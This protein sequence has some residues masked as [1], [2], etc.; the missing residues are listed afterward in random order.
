MGAQR[1]NNKVNGH[2]VLSPHRSVA[3]PLPT[4]VGRFDVRAFDMASGHLYVAVSR[5][6]LAGADGVLC[7]LHSECLTGDVFGSL[8]CDCGTQLRTALRLI[9]AEDRGVLIYATGHEGRGIG[10][11]NKLRAY[12]VQDGGA[13]TVDANVLLGLPIDGRDYGDAAAVLDCL[14][15]SSVRLLTNNPAKVAGLRAHGTAV[16]AIV[17]LPTVGHARNNGYLRTKELRLGH[18]RPTGPPID[19]LPDT[20]PGLTVDVGVLLGEVRPQPDRPYVA[21][22]YAQTIDGRIA[23]VGGRAEQISGAPEQMI[24][25]ALRAACDAV[26]VGRGTV[27]ADDPRLTV[28]AVPGVSPR[29]VVLDSALRVAAD[30]RVLDPDAATTIVTTSNAPTDRREALQRRGVHVVVVDEDADHRPDLA[31][32]LGALRREGVESVLVEGGA[33]VITGL[34]AARL[35]DR[36]IVAIAPLVVGSGVEA[37]GELGIRRIGDGIRLV[38]RSVHPVGDDILLAGDVA[39]AA[40]SS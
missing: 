17:P 29:R 9:E 35:V 2:R 23:T 39:C 6:E 1:G 27:V 34:L 30:A 15:V 4:S 3:V 37:V 25:H 18:L 10:L 21:I 11:V 36:M 8:R 20:G 40:D 13:D 38:E 12:A 5:G 31:A 16:T 28:R 33:A 22:K 14:G 32:A 24:S 19:A 7:R 26:L